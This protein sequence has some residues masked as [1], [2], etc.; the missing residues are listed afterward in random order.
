MNL[1]RACSQRELA[2]EHYSDLRSKPFFNGLV[3]FI[4]SSPVVAMVWQ[5]EDAGRFRVLKP[6]VKFRACA[7]SSRQHHRGRPDIHAPDL[8]VQQ[9]WCQTNSQLALC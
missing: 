4:I 6:R 3:E 8:D 7:I 5:G 2:E 1:T 9:R